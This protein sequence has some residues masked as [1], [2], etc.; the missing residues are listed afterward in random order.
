MKDLT[1]PLHG[2]SLIKQALPDTDWWLGGS[3]KTVRA[4]A[5]KGIKTA[6]F[7]TKKRKKERK[8]EKER[9]N[10]TNTTREKTARASIYIIIHNEITRHSR[11]IYARLLR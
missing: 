6:P 2:T 10:R 7:S 4:A 8:M 9:E 3:I 5:G 1:C 11:G